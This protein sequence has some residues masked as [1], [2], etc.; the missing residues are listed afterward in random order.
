MSLNGRF[1]GKA[2]IPKTDLSAARL[3][4]IYRTIL[5]LVCDILGRAR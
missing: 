5:N 3:G 4:M 2:D 1:W